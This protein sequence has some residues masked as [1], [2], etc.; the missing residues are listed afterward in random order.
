M[1]KSVVEFSTQKE[2]FNL[3]KLNIMSTFSDNRHDKRQY[4][5]E[6]FFLD[7]RQISYVCRHKYEQIS[8]FFDGL[9]HALKVFELTNRQPAFP[10]DIKWVSK[11][12][13][14]EYQA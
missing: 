3:N 10:V 8:A 12:E 11:K 6:H 4:D 13:R 7:S 2:I 9:K 5:H 14:N 1:L